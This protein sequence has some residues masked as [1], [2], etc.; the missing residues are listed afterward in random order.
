MRTSRSRSV[1]PVADLGN[2][3]VGRSPIRARAD[4]PPASSPAPFGSSVAAIEQHLPVA[5]DLL[6]DLLDERTG[7]RPKQVREAL[8]ETQPFLDRANAVG[9]IR[10]P[11]RAVDHLVQ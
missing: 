4:D 5:V 10:E 3:V 7:L 11:V 1:E 9:S 6:L 8:L 2:S